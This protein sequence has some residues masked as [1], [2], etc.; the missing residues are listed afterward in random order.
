LGGLAVVGELNLKIEVTMLARIGTYVG[1]LGLQ[2][3][4]YQCH[5]SYGNNDGTAWWFDIA[6]VM[7]QATETS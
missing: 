7:Y 4:Q 3:F 5:P 1:V 6:Y 2:E